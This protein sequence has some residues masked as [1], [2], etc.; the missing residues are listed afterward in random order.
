MTQE[1][2][3]LLERIR[4]EGVEK[5]RA[6]A[7]S[8][9][10]A[11]SKEAAGIV[12]AAREEAET[13]RKEAERDAEAFAR[14]AEESIRQAARDVQTQVAQALQ[15]RFERLLLEDVKEA[16]ADPQALAKWISQAVAAYLEGGEKEIEVRLGGEA[17]RHAEMLRARLREEASRPEGLTIGA[18]ASFPHGFTVRLDGGRVE[19]SFTAEAVTEALARLLRPRLAA[20]LSTEE[21]R[22]E[23]GGRAAE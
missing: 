11:A 5:A 9:L 19:H 6:E 12:A 8:I 14:R 2:Q 23:A 1:L 17:A 10:D 20:L 18:D 7:R 13:I 3:E 21:G 4:E 22:D 15:A 16:L